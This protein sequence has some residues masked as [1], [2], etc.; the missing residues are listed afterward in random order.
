MRPPIRAAAEIPGRLSK[1]RFMRLPAASRA[2][3]RGP[4]G[5][6]VRPGGAS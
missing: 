6:V 3:E 2:A 4:A 5:T 1:I